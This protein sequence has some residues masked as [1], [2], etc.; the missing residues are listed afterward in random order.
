MSDTETT[1]GETFDKSL[2]VAVQACVADERTAIVLYLYRAAGR[3]VAGGNVSVGDYVAALADTI[4][5]GEHH[6]VR[7]E[8]GN[9]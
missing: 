3:L 2:E 4:I 6:K 8:A 7:E 5:D 9:E 1:T